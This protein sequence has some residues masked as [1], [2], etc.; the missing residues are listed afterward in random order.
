MRKLKVLGKKSCS[1]ILALTMAAVLMTGCGAK[2]EGSSVSTPTQVEETT[3][4]NVTEMSEN[5]TEDQVEDKAENTTGEDEMKEDSKVEEVVEEVEEP[6]EEI[7]IPEACYLEAREV[8][9]GYGESRGLSAAELVAE[10]RT[11]WNL[12]NTMDASGGER[13]WG[14]PETTP[15]MIDAI[16]AKGFNIIRIPTSWGQFTKDKE[17]DYLIRTTWLMR[18]GEIVDY[19][20]ANDMY[21]IVNTHHETDWI[22]PTRKDLPD[23]EEKYI[24]IWTQIATYFAGYG[25]HLIFEGLNEPRLVGGTKEWNGGMK[26]NREIINQLNADFVETVRAAGGNNENRLLLITSEAACIDDSALKDVVVPEDVCIG[27]SLHA[28]TPYDFTFSHDGDYDTWNGDHKKDITWAFGQMN[29]YFLEKGVPVV[30]TEYGAVRKGSKSE[31]NDAE[32][33]KWIKDYLG[34]AEEYGIPAIIWDNGNT[35]GGGE[36]FGFFNRPKCTWDR[37]SIVDAI[38]ETTK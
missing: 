21:V 34:T 16:A 36:R 17:E 3:D 33:V 4:S 20:L 10:L 26:E 23:Y 7:S 11:G 30:V 12:G 18:V 38:M 22:K 19:A 2:D 37:E 25:D 28:Y 9:E 8:P 32:V 27:M 14:N 13:A 6:V 1:L 15:E 31:N 35:N 5:A 24:A 29:K